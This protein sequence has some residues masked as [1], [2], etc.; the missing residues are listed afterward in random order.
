MA[1]KTPTGQIAAS[2]LRSVFGETGANGRV[3][4]GNFRVT[5]NV[6]QMN[7]LPLDEGVP[8]SGQITFDDLRDKRL[9]VIVRYTNSENRPNTG[10]QRFGTRK[11]S[12]PG[13]DVLIL[14]P[15]GSTLNVPSDSSGCRVTLHVTNTIGSAKGN[16]THCALKT[17]GA[18]ES[19]TRLE[20]NVGGSGLISGAG[21]NG[22]EGGRNHN[23]DGS[24]GATGTSALGVAYSVHSIV[25][26]SG[27]A[28][29]AGGGGGGGG[30][31]AREDSEENDRRASGGGG[32]GGA[33]VPSGDGGAGGGPP[34]GATSHGK[35]EGD[36]GSN[37]STN[38]GGDGGD[39]GH[40][41]NE[42]RGGGGG[43]GGS[44]GEKGEGGTIRS[45][46]SNN[47]PGGEGNS[48]GGG[49]GGAGRRSS[50]KDGPTP[51]EGGAGGSNG[52]AII[53]KPGQSVGSISGNSR[54]KGDT[55]YNST[56]D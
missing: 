29:R 2:D 31:G 18:W 37:G 17:G 27:G 19:D 12:S 39:G 10:Y 54:I 4:L 41:D 28:I 53:V 50:D 52:Y 46:G 49:D 43:G 51:S 42:A 36:S 3:D 30:G 15:I 5:H 45:G 24:A 11:G 47:F 48:S 1:S 55:L 7:N 33:G 6:D 40:N 14:R 21:G 23:E 35:D 20:I 56:F 8:Q 26:Q 44:Y 34:Q 25:V 32:G 22:G 16:R 9:N 38:G 13:G